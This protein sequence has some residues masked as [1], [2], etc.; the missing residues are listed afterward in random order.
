MGHL[1]VVPLLLVSFVIFD[2]ADLTQLGQTLAGMVG[3]NGAGISDSQAL[4]LLGSYGPVLVAALVLSLPVGPA[5][6]TKLERVSWWPAARAILAPVTMAALLLA[7]TA[8]LV[9]GSF[10]PFLYFRF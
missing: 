3:L 4:Y 8:F 6:A 10:N 5:L 9:D 7:C 2:S 1:Y